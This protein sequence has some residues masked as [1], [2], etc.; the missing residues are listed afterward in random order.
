MGW[1]FIQGIRFD[2]AAITL[3]NAAIIL[4]Y[5]IPVK[6]TWMKWQCLISAL[7][8]SLVNGFFLT[9]NVI[10]IE[11]YRFTGKRFT[12]DSFAV[13]HDIR[14]QLPQISLYYWPYAVLSVGLFIGLFITSRRLLRLRSPDLLIPRISSLALLVGLLTVTGRGG[15]QHKPLIPAQAF[16]GESAKLGILILN[17]SFTLMKSS[18]ES[19]LARLNFMPDTEAHE[20]LSA[21]NSGES[22]ALTSRPKNIV[23][24]ILESFA[25]EYVF[26]PQNKK[27]YAP[28]LQSLAQRG[29][30]FHYAFANGRRSIDALPAVFAGIPNWMESPFITSPY[31]TN[32]LQALPNLLRAQGMKTQFFHGGDNGTMFFDVMA[33]RFG[34]E[35]YIGAHEYPNQSDHDGRWGIFDEPFLQ[36]AVQRLNQNTKPFLAGIFSLSS[37]QPYTVPTQYH[38]RFPRGGLDIHE[39][40]GYADYSLQKFYESA[41][42][43]AWFKDTLFIFTADHTQKTEYSE[44]ETSLGRYRVP[45]I[46]I[47]NNQPLPFPNLDRPAQHA[48]ILATV[49]DALGLPAHTISHFGSSLL[50]KAERPG[51]VLFESPRYLLVG[52]NQVL[53][54]NISNERLIA[55]DWP[56]DIL[57]KSP[58]ALEI[59]HNTEQKFLEAQVQCFNNGMLDNILQW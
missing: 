23:I 31:Q 32:S 20:I 17:S 28:F 22:I 27:S 43:Q 50:K 36:Y 39:S 6:S 30:S 2:M 13:G 26:P 57:L 24:V 53:D 42:Q 51:V 11:Y 3:S 33:D 52:K 29:S 49:F 9:I 41:E 48:D 4:F 7:A 47:Q 21:S 40:I 37:H 10:D 45:L 44:Y 38:N 5:F 34:F 59:S 58:R 25:H 16:A 55:F 12:L 14:Q 1:A 18:Q 8:V 19:K 15:W 54:W 35:D 56:R 46:F